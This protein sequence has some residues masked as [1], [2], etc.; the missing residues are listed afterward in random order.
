[1]H[2]HGPG[3][4]IL[5]V[6]RAQVPLGSL[7]GFALSARVVLRLELWATVLLE[8]DGSW[9][10]TLDR[11]SRRFVSIAQRDELFLCDQVLSFAVSHEASKLVTLNLPRAHRALLLRHD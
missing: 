9:N 10:A 11:S 1:M 3:A 4:S 5:V 6:L 7:I 2:A 8:R